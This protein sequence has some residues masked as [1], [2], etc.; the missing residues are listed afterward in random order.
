MGFS[1]N[2]CNFNN[3]FSLFGWPQVLVLD[4]LEWRRL[5]VFASTTAAANVPDLASVAVYLVLKRRLSLSATPV[6]ESREEEDLDVYGG[7]YM[8]EQQQGTSMEDAGLCPHHTNNNS[9]NSSN[10]A[11]SFMP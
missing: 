8:G 11:S 10:N 3:C 5:I 9:N 2:Y 4:M 6:E 1:K 7:I